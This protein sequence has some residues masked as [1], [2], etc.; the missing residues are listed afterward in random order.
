M[1]SADFAYWLSIHGEPSILPNQSKS[2]EHVMER[3]SES[4]LIS[5]LYN[6]SDELALKALKILK[7]KFNDELEGL[8]EMIQHQSMG[9]ENR[10]EYANDWN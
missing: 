6:G 4:D 5:V 10:D 7:F 9:R 8:E 2:V 3:L 1:I